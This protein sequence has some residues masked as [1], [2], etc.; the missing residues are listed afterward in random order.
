MGGW[1]ALGEESVLLLAAGMRNPGM[2]H[3]G[4]SPLSAQARVVAKKTKNLWLEICVDMVVGA[5]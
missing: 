3:T 2:V 4:P 1:P 5:E